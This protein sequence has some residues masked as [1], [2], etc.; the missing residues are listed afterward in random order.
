VSGSTYYMRV[1]GV[2]KFGPLATGLTCG[3]LYLRIWSFSGWPLNTQVEVRSL[4][5]KSA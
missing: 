1:D 3:S 4:T 2:I 5:V